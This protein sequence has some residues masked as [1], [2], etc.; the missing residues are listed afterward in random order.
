MKHLRL[1]EEFV[2]TEYEELEVKQSSIPNSGRGLFTLVDIDED[3]K[4]A[5]FTGDIISE[6]EASQLEGERGHYLIA[7]GSGEILDV[8]NSDSPAIYANDAYMS[9]KFE[10]NSVIREI[11]GKVWLMSTRDIYG[12]EEIFC[13]YGEDYW[14]NWTP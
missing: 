11:D 10:N 8:Y 5:E 1:F 13:E 6:E 2:N 12:G 3:S 4:I 14:D 7:L 9:D